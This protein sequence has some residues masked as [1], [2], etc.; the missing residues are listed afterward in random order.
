M[1][2]DGLNY[3]KFALVAVSVVL[4][5]VIGSFIESHSI[6]SLL[7]LLFLIGYAVRYIII[8]KIRGNR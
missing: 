4:F 8:S 2:D 3:K 1:Q 5:F 7:Y 6:Y